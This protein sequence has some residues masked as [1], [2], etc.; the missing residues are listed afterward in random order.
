MVLISGGTGCLVMIGENSFRSLTEQDK[1]NIK[2]FDSDVIGVVDTSM[3]KYLYEIT[4]NDI[5]SQTRTNAYTWVHIWLPYCPNEHCQNIAFFPATAAQYDSLS[6]MII[7]ATY[8]LKSISRIKQLSEYHQPV[9]VLKDADYSHKLKETRVQFS[10]EIGVKDEEGYYAD[11]LIF[12]DSTLIYAGDD[13]AE[14]LDSIFSK[15]NLNL[16]R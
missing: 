6:L 3:N 8:D 16:S 5:M 7:S 10:Q 11:D 9:F 4:A 13:G 14:I 15:P 12:R 1:T 2:P